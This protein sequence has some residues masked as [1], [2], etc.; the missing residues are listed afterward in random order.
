MDQT[1]LQYRYLA[2]RLILPKVFRLLVLALRKLNPDELERDLLLDQDESGTAGGTGRVVAVE[3]DDHD[4][5]LGGE[6]GETEG[7]S[8]D[9]NVV[10]ALFNH[11]DAYSSLDK[12]PREHLSR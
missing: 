12:N 3:S 2:E 5:E 10:S 4:Q 1:Y 9:R 7:R 11:S 8:E 6:L